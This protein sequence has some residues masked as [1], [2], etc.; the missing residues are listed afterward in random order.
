M[1]TDALHYRHFIPFGVLEFLEESFTQA[2]GLRQ[3]L[4]VTVRLFDSEA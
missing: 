4:P 3:G 2:L 1:A